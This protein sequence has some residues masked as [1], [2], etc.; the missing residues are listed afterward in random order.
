MIYSPTSHYILQTLNTKLMYATT[1][2]VASV[3]LCLDKC[4]M[5]FFM[6]GEGGGG[7]TRGF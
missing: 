3:I 1:T 7:V 6:W 4:N 2:K 5:I